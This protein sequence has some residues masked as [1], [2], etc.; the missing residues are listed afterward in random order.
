MSTPSMALLRGCLRNWLIAFR[1]RLSARRRCRGPRRSGRG[2]MF[3]PAMAWQI[4]RS[5]DAGA[6]VPAAIDEVITS[7]HLP[8]RVVGEDGKSYPARRRTSARP[9]SRESGP[10]GS[11]PEPA[12]A[13]NLGPVS[14]P[15]VSVVADSEVGGVCG[16]PL[17]GSALD[18]EP[19]P[20]TRPSRS[21]GSRPSHRHDPAFD[22]QNLLAQEDLI[23]FGALDRS[24]LAVW[25]ADLDR[26]PRGLGRLIRRL[27]EAAGNG[28]VEAARQGDEPSAPS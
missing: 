23:D 27:R 19:S 5:V 21:S 3:A 26:A 15:A 1:G 25:I 10:D 11:G 16:Q 8:A 13:P 22:A 17:P 14:E 12:S 7:C 4:T 20:A 28:A 2:K 6:Q 18:G 9:A 24:M